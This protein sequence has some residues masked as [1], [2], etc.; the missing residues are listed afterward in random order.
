MPWYPRLQTLQTPAA[1]RVKNSS[2]LGRGGPARHAQALSLKLNIGFCHLRTIYVGQDTAGEPPKEVW[3][4]PAM[5]PV[6]L[7]SSS[8]YIRLATLME[9]VKESLS[10]YSFGV[11]VF[12]FFALFCFVCRFV[13]VLFKMGVFP[14]L[15]SN[16]L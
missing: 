11:F 5:E 16:F 9:I 14:R 2:R 10:L 3:D 1:G 12:F 4:P 7:Q 6:P 15:A 8:L 13:F